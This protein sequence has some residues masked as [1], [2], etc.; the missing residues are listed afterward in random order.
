LK[1]WNRLVAVR[2]QNQSENRIQNQ[3]R[4]QSQSQKLKLLSRA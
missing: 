1:G 3:N 2:S 4:I